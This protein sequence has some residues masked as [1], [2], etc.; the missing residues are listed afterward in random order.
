MLF[1][2]PGKPTK[3]KKVIYLSASIV[4]GVLLS[5]IVHVLIEINYLSW[6]LKHGQEVKL[7]GVCAFH[8]ILQS[9][10]WI[11]GVIGG[12]FVG[13]FWWV[14]VYIAR[15]WEKKKIK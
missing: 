9:A 7:Y 15:A 10:F 3:T 11:V 5:L 12:F 8:P 14:K 4:L 6:A 2:R 1:N 13:K